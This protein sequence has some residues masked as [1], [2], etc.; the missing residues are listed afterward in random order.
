MPLAMSNFSMLTSVIPRSQR[1]FQANLCYISVF[2][3]LNTFIE[4]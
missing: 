1:S 4:N 3:G 2:Y